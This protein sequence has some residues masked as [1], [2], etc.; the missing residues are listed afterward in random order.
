MLRSIEELEKYKVQAN[1]GLVG[2]VRDFFFDDESW[3][4]RY[5]VVET[6]QWLAERDVL[7]SPI[8][9]GRVDAEKKQVL[10]LLDQEKIQNSPDIDSDMPVSR[11][12][13][14]RYLD[15]YDYPYYWGGRGLW[16]EGSFPSL[17]VADIDDRAS[18]LAYQSQQRERSERQ[19]ES[20]AGHVHADP[21]SV[22][23]STAAGS[24]KHEDPHLRSC[25]SVVNHEIQ[26]TDGPIGHVDGFLVDEDTWAI[27]YLVAQTGHWWSDHKVLIAPEWITQVNW[28]QST[29]AVDLSRAA[30]RESPLFGSARELDR[31]QEARLYKHYDR[32]GYW[33]DRPL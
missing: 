22:A 33:N 16:G 1:D 14:K 18:Q 8:S 6:G 9:I 5:L 30:I 17:M 21:S 10:V 23:A 2:H 7:I 26:A 28:F 12:H 31:E 11:Q 20:Q 24:A 19:G 13:E 27:R 15:Y 4:V 3:V 29:V 32:S 25:K